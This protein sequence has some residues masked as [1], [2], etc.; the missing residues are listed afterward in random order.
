M[1]KTLHYISTGGRQLP[2]LV[3]AC[4]RPYLEL[5]EAT[6]SVFP[7]PKFAYYGTHSMKCGAA[8]LRCF[9][10]THY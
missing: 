5:I 2:P 8:V 4:G 3:H 1:H 6:T 7:A 10:I 9:V